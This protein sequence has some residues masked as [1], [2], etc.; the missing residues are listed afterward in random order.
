MPS[1]IGEQELSKSSRLV[2][3]MQMRVRNM[4]MDKIRELKLLHN[5]E[6]GKVYADLAAQKLQQ[7]ADQSA[8]LEQ[9]HHLELEQKATLEEF[10]LTRT[11]SQML[12]A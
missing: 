9:Q 1:N 7:Q 11:R 8:L 3:A 5:E 12:Q 4:L 2:I 6:I 10:V